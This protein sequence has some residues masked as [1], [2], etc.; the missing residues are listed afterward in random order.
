[1]AEQL[2]ADAAQRR[3]SNVRFV[4]PVP[5]AEALWLVDAC[6]IGYAGGKDFPRLYKFGTSFN[7]IVDF[8]RMGLPVL[9]PFSSANGPAARSG[10]GICA[11]NGEAES[12]AKVFTQLL[13]MSPED[14]AAMGERGR[15]FVAEQ[16]NYD[17]V[18]ADYIAAIERT[19]K[20][21]S[22]A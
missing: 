15:A 8:M 10:A 22:G 9:L 11:D 5:K 3:L 16:L 18:A 21:R 14:R 12:V 17:K 13:D 19:Q 6:D 7:K 4:D 20:R 1:M 2:K